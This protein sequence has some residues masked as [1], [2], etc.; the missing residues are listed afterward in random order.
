[1]M[2]S[3]TM[4]CVKYTAHLEKMMLTGFWWRNEE[5]DHLEDLGTDRIL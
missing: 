1:M 4:K 3:R 5:R 2:N